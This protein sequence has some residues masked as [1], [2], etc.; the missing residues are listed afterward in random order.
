MI[1]S[2]ALDRTA[3]LIITPP[4]FPFVFAMDTEL[5]FAQFAVKRATEIAENMAF[6]HELIIHRPRKEALIEILSA[7]RAVRPDKE[8]SD[9]K[10]AKLL[11]VSPSD[12]V[13]NV[14]PDGYTSVT[15]KH[16]AK[17][18][19]RAMRQNK[20]Y[21]TKNLFELL[22]RATRKRIFLEG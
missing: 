18:G 11:K 4:P 3:V 10:M 2:R 16:G 9:A 13:K 19:T 22:P 17:L 14:H 8:M 6:I 5:E 12:W 21:G 20:K 1:G 7:N 15:V